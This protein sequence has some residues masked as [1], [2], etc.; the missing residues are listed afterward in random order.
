MV[1]SI[2][3][4]KCK[5]L[6]DIQSLEICCLLTEN[7]LIYRHNLHILLCERVMC[8]AQYLLYVHGIAREHGNYMSFFPLCLFCL[9]ISMRFYYNNRVSSYRN[10]VIN[11]LA[12]LRFTVEI[13]LRNFFFF[14]LSFFF[15]ASSVDLYEFFS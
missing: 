3:H 15:C 6:S 11:K 13:L 10:A 2:K 8:M 7:L 4:G 1:N 12:F 9:F 14:S 5:Y